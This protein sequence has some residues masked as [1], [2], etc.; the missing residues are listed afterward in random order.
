MGLSAESFLQGRPGVGIDIVDVLDMARR[1]KVPG[2]AEYF[3]TPE[4]ITYCTNTKNPSLQ[5]QRFAARWAAKEATIKA[6]GGSGPTEV[7]LRPDIN[8]KKLP[9]GQ[10]T[11]ELLGR[12]RL[13]ADELGVIDMALSL[14]HIR[15]LAI[16]ICEASFNHPLT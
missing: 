6:M 4:E 13:R 9:S 15:T 5:A 7:D 1:L 8:I 16:A 10:P 12:A 2:F 11:V 14:S 3:C